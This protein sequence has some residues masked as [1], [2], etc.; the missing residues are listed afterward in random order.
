[1]SQAREYRGETMLQ[2]G[3]GTMKEDTGSRMRLCYLKRIEKEKT[4]ITPTRDI[5]IT[6]L[7]VIAAIRDIVITTKGVAPSITTTI[8]RCYANHRG[9]YNNHKGTLNNNTGT[10]WSVSENK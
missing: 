4:R 6:K 5:I 3:T 8:Q 7:G 9:S 2:R 1:M 10:H